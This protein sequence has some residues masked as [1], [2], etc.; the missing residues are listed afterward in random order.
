[1]HDAAV[2]GLPPE[3]CAFGPSYARCVPWLK[4]NFPSVLSAEER[5][6]DEASDDENADA[7]DA[8]TGAGGAEASASASAAAAE[9]DAAAAAAAAHEATGMAKKVVKKGGKE[10]KV[11]VQ[12]KQ[13]KGR[14]KWLTLV[15]GA[16]DFGVKL[17]DIKKSLS[18]K[19]AASAS[20]TENAKGTKM[21]QVGGEVAEEV[22]LFMH[23]EYG[24]PLAR[25]FVVSGKKVIPATSL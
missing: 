5:G 18:G 12:A 24:I 21:V 23:S 2:C 3:Y 7:E 17:K 22:A 11:L 14:K 19:F 10:P 8:S 13:V 9:A 20:I 16:E 25:V 4:V 1:L 15:A 6:D